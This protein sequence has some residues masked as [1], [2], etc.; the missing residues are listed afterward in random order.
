MITLN[1]ISK[2]FSGE[3]VLKEVSLSI[4]SGEIIC[5]IGPSGSGKTTLLR[6]L[7]F[8]EPADSGQIRIDDVALDCAKAGKKE[9]EKLR[10]KT[11]MV[12]QSWNLF[13]NLTALQNIT[14]GL[15]YAK[16][17]PRQEALAI[18]E[19]L[20]KQVGLLHKKDHYPHSLSGGQKQRIG[21]ARALAIN[22]AVLLL[23]EPTSALDPEKV[24][25]V[26]ELIQT[27]AAAGQTMIIVTHEMA[28]ARQV[29][30]RMVFMENG[31][32]VEQGPAEQIFGAAQQGRTRAFLA[33]LHYHA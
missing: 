14:E 24:G 18:A 16:K 11:A 6:T 13:H 9:I 10:S 22:P 8:L 23:D 21:I 12:F 28:F 2:S 3:R 19:R 1:K 17:R 15:I 4:H 5:I 20:L 26:L 32:I 7:N 25:E 29:A 27:I 30:S 33:Q 31:E